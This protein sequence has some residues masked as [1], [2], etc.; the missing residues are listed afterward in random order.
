MN[1]SITLKDFLRSLISKEWVQHLGSFI[2][3][4]IAPILVNYPI[5]DKSSGISFF[6]YQWKFI[7]FIIIYG[8]LVFITHIINKSNKEK[9]KEAGLMDSFIDNIQLLEGS[10][11]KTNQQVINEGSKMLF[12]KTAQLVCTIIQDML[13]AHYSGVGIRVCITKQLEGPGRRK[14]IKQV[15]YKSPTCMAASNTTLPLNTFK[16]FVGEIIRSNTEDYYLFL[17][18]KTVDDNLI[19]SKKKAAKLKP[20]QFIAIPYKGSFDKICFVLQ[21]DF[22]TEK[23]LSTNISDVQEYINKYIRPFVLRL[24]NVYYSDYVN[25]QWRCNHE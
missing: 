18:P 15:G 1:T 4:V 8:V 21:I 13:S 22:D 5:F 9:L 11:L 14:F 25:Q 19:F 3:A 12:D 24:G 20:K 2:A 23:T 16:Y 7:A 10:I 6:I 17:T